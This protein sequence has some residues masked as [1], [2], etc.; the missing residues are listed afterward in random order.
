MKKKIC[1]KCIVL[2]RERDLLLSQAVELT[3]I[4]AR[5]KRI[6]GHRASRGAK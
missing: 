3:K 6:A 4:L 2:K 1:R 5:L